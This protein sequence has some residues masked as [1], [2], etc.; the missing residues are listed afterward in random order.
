MRALGWILGLLVASV[1]LVTVAGYFSPREITVSRSLRIEAPPEAI[2]PYISDL[3]R[4]QEWE[5]WGP[6]DDSLRVRFGEVRRG[7]GASY[8]WK[9]DKT[10]EGRLEI[11]AIAPPLQVDYR[12]VFNGDEAGAA[13]SSMI[14]ERLGPSATRVTWS[15][16]V[17]LGENPISRL[18]GSLVAGGVEKQHDAGLRTLKQ[19]AEGQLA[20]GD[21]AEAVGAVAPEN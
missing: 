21:P 5:P 11:V 10:G 12:S 6:I 8:S 1:A 14:L 4:W 2:F 7:V 3:E 13:D 17:D 9:G 19:L 20:V 15:I 18:L 16:H